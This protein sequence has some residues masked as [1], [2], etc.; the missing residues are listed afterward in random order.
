MLY[1]RG[2]GRGLRS[3]IRETR[4]MRSVG[5]A[6]N[7]RVSHVQLWRRRGRWRRTDSGHIRERGRLADSALLLSV[8]SIVRD[9]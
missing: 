5:L 1:K 2:M 8:H 7:E 9:I 6:E 4:G 3:G